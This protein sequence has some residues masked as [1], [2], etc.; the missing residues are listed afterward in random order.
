[1]QAAIKNKQNAEPVVISAGPG[2]EPGDIRKVL[3]WFHIIT[4]SDGT[5]GLVS[6][7]NIKDQVAVMNQAY[8]GIF[9]F[10]LRGIK[11]YAL[12]RQNL[13]YCVHK[14]YLI[15]QKFPFVSTIQARPSR[16]RIIGSIAASQTP[17]DVS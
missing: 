2:G 8:R 17:M 15:Y 14:T 10:E 3:V 7:Q 5:Q 13:I 6:D 9:T 11:L 12:R 4:T 16:P 1:M